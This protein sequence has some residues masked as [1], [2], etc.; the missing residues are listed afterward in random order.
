M[1]QTGAR[2]DQDPDLADYC[3]GLDPDDG[4]TGDSTDT[5]TSETTGETGE[6]TTAGVFPRSF[7]PLD[8]ADCEYFCSGGDPGEGPTKL[9][10]CQ[11]VGV[12]DDCSWFTIECTYT[13]CMFTCGVGGRMHEIVES[14]PTSARSLGEWLAAVAHNEAASVHSFEALAEEL[15]THAAPE[16][17]IERALLAREDEVRHAT[18]M[19]MLA[20]AETV[21]PATP[22]VG[23]AAPR[24][25]LAI[26]IENAVE[27]CVHE[28][29]AAL[30]AHYQALHAPDVGLRAA[31][32]MIADDET[33]HA[34]LAWDID[35]WCRSR[36]SSAEYAHVER[37]R[38]TAARMRLQRA[39]VVHGFERE[40]GLPEPQVAEHLSRG[41]YDRLWTAGAAA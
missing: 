13:T 11:V 12:E 7:P 39:A 21:T 29:W 28:T 34:Q 19:A 18:M 27:G 2:P 22:Q 14:R 15:R 36:L 30:E 40:A 9:D 25:L 23:A 33:R 38:E 32:R 8:D 37:A 5:G 20:R 41:L 1:L 31:M 6:G 10:Y 26:A 16:E 3:E 4:E 17:L 24:S 35:A